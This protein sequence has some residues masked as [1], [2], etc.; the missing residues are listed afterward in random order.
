MPHELVRVVE[1]AYRARLPSS[2]YEGPS[3][4]YRGHAGRRRRAD[5]HEPP[6]TF[7]DDADEDQSAGGISRGARVR[8]PKFGVGTVV[9]VEP[10]AGDLKLSIRFTGVGVKKILARYA[11]LERV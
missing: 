9:G 8:H 4:G 10:A 7:Y 1:P 11:K 2:G 6:A 5:S 3:R